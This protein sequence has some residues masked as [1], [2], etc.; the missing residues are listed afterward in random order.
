LRSV[1]LT[2]I[3]F[4]LVIPAYASMS[5][6]SML[7]NYSDQVFRPD[8]MTL[9]IVTFEGD[10]VVFQNTTIEQYP[11]SF[12]EYKL[13]SYLPEHN[14]WALERTGYEWMDWLV[15]NGNNGSMNTVISE[16]WPS[17]DGS[18]FYCA[19]GNLYIEFM[20]NGI[21]I[22]RFDEDSI[23]IEFEDLDVPW[24]PN[25]T[26]WLSDSVLVLEK[27]YLTWDCRLSSTAPG[28]LV[29]SSDGEWITD[30]PESWE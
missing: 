25:R 7:R 13:I 18:R 2:A 9:C 26:Q 4:S 30:D 15:V 1:L 6:E 17:P 10:T 20:E 14:Y 3:V 24:E 12:S 27:M 23:S 16:P 28:R 21:Q 19:Q 11:D 5:E 29:L 22:W 8:S